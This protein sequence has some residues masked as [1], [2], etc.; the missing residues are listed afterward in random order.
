MHETRPFELGKNRIEAL[1]DGIFA[2]VMTLLILEIHVPDLPANASNL[3]LAPA[4]WHLWPKFLSY[5]VSFVALGV[6]WISHHNIYHLIRRSDRVREAMHEQIQRGHVLIDTDGA[7]AGQVNGLS[8]LQLGNFAFGN[9]FKDHAIE[10]AW[11]LVTKDFGLPKDRL[12]AT[13][14]IDDDVAFDLWKKIAGLPE[15]AP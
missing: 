9:Y 15:S 10:L 4:L 12:T 6:Y 11:N 2:I 14:Y 5:A 1:S 3:Q 8:V 7:K 13:V